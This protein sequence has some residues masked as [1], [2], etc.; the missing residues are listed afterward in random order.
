MVRQHYFIT[1]TDTGV[2]K[3]RIACGL[4][5]AANKQ[6][7]STL[8]LKP[9][10]SGCDYI[11]GRWRNEDAVALQKVATLSLAYEQINP[12]ALPQAIAPHLAAKAQGMTLCVKNL[13]RHYQSLQPLAAQFVVVEGAGG[14]S[15]PLNATETLADFAVA[16]KLPVI[17]VVG[18]RLGC[19]NHALLTAQAIAA[20]HLTL[21]G[22]VANC[23]EP[24]TP[25]QDNIIASL[26][27]RIK[28]PCIGCVPFINNLTE[29]SDL[30]AWIKLNRLVT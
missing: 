11:D 29:N 24:E 6:S 19:I 18:I 21:A 28:S 8:G 17:L 4:L 20:T 30:S 22:W 15:V 12:I 25:E 23:V 1:G 10:A 27:T 14:W 3:T 13:L 9:I 7:L 5:Q 16:L 2:G 26:T